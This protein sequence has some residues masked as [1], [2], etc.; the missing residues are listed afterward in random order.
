[1]FILSARLPRMAAFLL[2]E[3]TA[4]EY[5]ETKAE[6]QEQ[7]REFQAFLE[8]SLRGDM[9]LVDEFGAGTSFAGT[10]GAAEML[11]DAAFRCLMNSDW[12]VFAVCSA[13]LAIQAAVSEAFK[14]PEVI[15]MFANKQPDQLR[16]RLAA[17]QRDVKLKAA[18][19][20]SKEAFQRQAVEILVALKKMGTELTPEEA[21]Y[22]ESASSAAQLESAV[23][24]VGDVVQAS[25]T[26][27]ASKQVR[28]AEQ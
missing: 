20:L 27:A 24:N 28:R 15:R 5:N 7:L 21:A 18:G 1:M 6:T 4:D 17:L 16:L 12:F 11:H 10:G 26:S 14:T 22:L 8:R 2:S 19:A 3:F 9:S 13:Q 23:D 25:L